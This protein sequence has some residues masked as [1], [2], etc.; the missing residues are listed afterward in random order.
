MTPVGGR[1]EIPKSEPAGDCESWLKPDPLPEPQRGDRYPGDRTAADVAV[2]NLSPLWGSVHLNVFNL[3]LLTAFGR[4]DAPSP[5][6]G[7]WPA[8]PGLGHISLPPAGSRPR[9]FI[10]RASGASQVHRPPVHL[11]HPAPEMGPHPVTPTE[12]ATRASG[13]I[14]GMCGILLN[15]PQACPERGRR[16]SRMDPSIRFAHS[17]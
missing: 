14:H 2:T 13:G 8:I 11:R 1:P 4:R 6:S 3:G 9:L 10:F 7:R 17:G 5:A 16:P 15:S 12:G